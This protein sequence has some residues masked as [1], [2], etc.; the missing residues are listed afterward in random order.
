MIAPDFDLRLLSG[1]D[2]HNRELWKLFCGLA[3]HLDDGRKVP[4]GE[5]ARIVAALLFTTL[6]S[7][8]GCSPP[9]FDLSAWNQ[10]TGRAR[11]RRFMWLWVWLYCRTMPRRYTNSAPTWYASYE[12]ARMLLPGVARNF[13]PDRDEMKHFVRRL[14]RR[15]PAGNP[16]LKHPQ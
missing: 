8:H 4:V 16:A 6:L 10:T 2:H 14:R 5:I 11:R 1:K 7:Q 12:V 3:F 9:G 15:F 13:E